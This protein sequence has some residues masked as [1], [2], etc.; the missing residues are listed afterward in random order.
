MEPG[1]G[2]FVLWVWSTRGGD[3]TFYQIPDEGTIVNRTPV[4][5][6][7][8]DPNDLTVIAVDY[9]LR[10]GCVSFVPTDSVEGTTWVDFDS[11]E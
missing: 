10:R 1:F 7:S 8:I 5:V 6:R 3:L 2:R 11:S 4:E 9:R